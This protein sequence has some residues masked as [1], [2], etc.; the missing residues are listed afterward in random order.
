M[1]ILPWRRED[2]FPTQSLASWIQR[3]FDEDGWF[4][5][6]FASRLPA[7]FTSANIPPV[8]VA[9]TEQA[10]TVN[11]ELP[12]LDEKDIDVT[13]Q[14]NQLTIRAERK[15]EEEKKDT[16]YHRVERQYGTFTRTLPMPDNLKSDAIDA[17]Y[18][19]GV[20]TITIPKVEPTPAAKVKVRAG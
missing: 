4:N 2:A 11:V 12:G 1:K 16:R 10:I 6:P 9:E 17:R 20:L 5:A 8:D 7:T 15:F 19:N 14:G 18:K 13:F 3:F